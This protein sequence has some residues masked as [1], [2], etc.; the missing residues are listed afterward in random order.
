MVD[1]LSLA[2]L[3]IY[4]LVMLGVGYMLG[5]HMKPTEG[6]KEE[7]TI[8]VKRTRPSFR[9]PNKTHRTSYDEYKTNKGLYAPVKPG[10]GSR[11]DEIEVK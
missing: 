11:A 1:L 8:M 4:S 6:K 7:Q 3:S 10:K 5:K 9:N 2:V